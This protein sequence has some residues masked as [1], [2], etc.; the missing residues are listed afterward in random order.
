[1]YIVIDLPGDIT[2]VMYH[3]KIKNFS[4]KSKKN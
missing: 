1:M 2:L 4:N 3:I